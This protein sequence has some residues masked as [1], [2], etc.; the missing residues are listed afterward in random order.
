MAG[1]AARLS[2]GLTKRSERRPLARLWPVGAVA[3]ALAAAYAM[4]LQRYL[5]FEVLAQQQDR[6]QALAAARPL[7][8]PVAF[9]AVYALAV[10][11]SLPGSAVL[12]IAGGLLFGT[13]LGAACAVVAATVGAVLLFLAARYAVGDWLAGRAGPLTG[14]IREGLQRDGFSY[15]LALRF[16]PVVPFWLV[17]LAPALVGMRLWPFAAATFLGIIP[18]TTVFASIGA[19]I[20]S[21]LAQGQRP[22]LGALFRPAVILPLL[23][24][25]LLSLLPVVWRRWKAHRG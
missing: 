2:P 11:V 23:G 20:G 14:R 17:N 12:T 19:G 1:K 7:L 10:A 6:L 13:A 9:I 24:L 15:L 21:V 16:I 5:S 18:G 4:G 8:A 25:A 22:D 3:L